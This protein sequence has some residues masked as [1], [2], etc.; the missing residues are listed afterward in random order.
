MSSVLTQNTLNLSFQTEFKI[1][2][3][4]SSIQKLILSSKMGEQMSDRSLEALFMSNDISPTEGINLGVVGCSNIYKTPQLVDR[5][6]F[7]QNNSKVDVEKCSEIRGKV[8]ELSQLAGKKAGGLNYFCDDKSGNTLECI[9][10]YLDTKTSNNARSGS[11]TNISKDCEYYETN[12]TRLT[13]DDSNVIISTS[14]LEIVARN[15]KEDQSFNWALLLTRIVL[16]S[17]IL[18]L[19]FYWLKHKMM[20]RFLKDII[21]LDLSKY[22]KIYHTNIE[23]YIL[24]SN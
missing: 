6:K 22:E 3:G 21:V 2:S 13:W 23:E 19:L 8:L 16:L 20:A 15:S 11:D 24:S 1:H 14:N 5:I 18:A 9:Q 10:D 17:T 4:Q 7:R 12:R